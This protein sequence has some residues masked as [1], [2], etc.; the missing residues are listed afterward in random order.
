MRKH[1]VRKFLGLTVL[2]AA[3]IVGIF[4]LQFKSESI[5]SKAIGP[6]HISIAQTESDTNVTELKNQFKVTFKGISFS[7]DDENPVVA[8]ASENSE[9]EKLVLKSFDETSLSASFTFNDGTVL[10]F[11]TSKADSDGELSVSARISDK[12]SSIEVPYKLSGNLTS[13]KLSKSHALLTAKKGF[14]MLTAHDILDDTV[15][16]TKKDSVAMFVTYDPSKRFSY[17]TVVGLEGTS[18]ASFDAEARRARDKFLSETEAILKTSAADSL[19]ESAVT[20]YVAEMASRDRYNEA[21]D[22]VPESLR[23]E[24]HRTYVSAPFFNTLAVMNRSLVVQTEQYSS[25]TASAVTSKNLDIFNID[26]ISDFII[27]EKKKSRITNLLSFPAQMA[28]FKPTVVQAAGILNVYADLYKNDASVA[29]LLEPVLAK[30]LDSIAQACSLENDA[31]K[32]NNNGAALSVRQTIEVGNAL[33]KYGDVSSKNE[34]AQT[35]YLIM[36]KALAAGLNVETAASVYH[37]LAESNFYYPHTQI[38]GYY[39]NTAVWAWTC[40]RNISYRIDAEN[41][42]NIDIDFPQGL[43]N[44]IIFNGV[45][46]FHGRIEIQGQMFRTDPRFETYNSSGYVYQTSTQSLLL[47]SRHKSSKETVRLFCDPTDSFSN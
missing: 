25:M 12:F 11:H 15:Q 26:G 1:P 39:G 46:T 35:G 23:R 32:I 47:K 40:A 18:R 7:A 34:Y 14:F 19:S 37:I 38:L 17:S 10:T 28:D 6:L 9:G 45:P 4:V 31:V 27:R 30:C 44:H 13:E 33:A 21:I 22:S 8:K 16:L 42:V 36:N 24:N 41:I 3:I 29:A 20:A 43:T 5:I 2:Y